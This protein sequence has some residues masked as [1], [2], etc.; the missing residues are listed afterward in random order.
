MHPS[1]I[2]SAYNHL[3]QATGDAEKQATTV[4]EDEDEVQSAVT[5]VSDESRQC[6]VSLEMHP[7]II[8]S[9]SNHLMQVT[10]DAEKQA[11]TVDD[12]QNESPIVISK[13]NGEIAEECS[14]NL[15]LRVKREAD[16]GGGQIAPSAFPAAH[17]GHKSLSVYVSIFLLLILFIAFAGIWRSPKTVKLLRLHNGAIDDL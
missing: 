3:M 10:E 12:L 13:A 7:S 17:H 5:E 9:P 16:S 11:T 6:G 15:R 1:I 4:D 8:F 2:F 14:S